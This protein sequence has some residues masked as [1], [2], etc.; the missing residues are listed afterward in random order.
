MW[1]R[2][3]IKDTPWEDFFELEETNNNEIVIK[4]YDW[5]R[6]YLATNWL[7]DLVDSHKLEQ[8]SISIIEMVEKP[9]DEWLYE[10]IAGQILCIQDHEKTIKHFQSLLS[11][12]E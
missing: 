8:P 1:Y 6:N 10:E 9:P 12:K 4:W 5:A 2:F 7:T 11:S 3:A